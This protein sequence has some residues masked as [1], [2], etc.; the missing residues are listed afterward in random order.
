MRR[1][2]RQVPAGGADPLPSMGGTRR[3]PSRAEERPPTQRTPD[4]QVSSPPARSGLETW[5][6]GQYAV[7]TTHAVSDY[8]CQGLHCSKSH[9]GCATSCA[10][11]PSRVNSSSPGTSATCKPVKWCRVRSPRRASTRP[12][13]T[14]CW[15][16]ATPRC[17]P[18]IRWPGSACSA[19]RAAR[20][21]PLRRCFSTSA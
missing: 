2:L 4:W 14:P 18:G 10:S 9:A 12:S 7:A 6:S 16:P 3:R 19:G 8:R 11:C 1:R 5:P 17:W 15:T 20:R 13:A 21:A